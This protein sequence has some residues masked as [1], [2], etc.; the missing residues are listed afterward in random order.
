MNI[1][2]TQMKVDVLV[3]SP[4]SAA[5][6]FAKTAA[7]RTPVMIVTNATNCLA[8]VPRYF[9]IIAGIVDP[10]FLKDI[11]PEKKSCVAPIKIV[12]KVIHK[13]AAG[14]NIAPCITPNIGPK[15]AIFKK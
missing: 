1:N 9:E 11:N 4:I 7:P 14:P 10:S 2:M 12:P 6:P 15:P 8:G 3:K 13:K 5:D